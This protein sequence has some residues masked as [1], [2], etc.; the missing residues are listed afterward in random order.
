[1]R[2]T[3]AKCPYDLVLDN[4]DTLR[5]VCKVSYLRCFD[6]AGRAV[7]FASLAVLLLC[8]FVR[9]DLGVSQA[10]QRGGKGG[11]GMD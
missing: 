1:M 4:Q 11:K 2:N 7:L 6:F 8:V 10:S 5:V 9:D 3:C